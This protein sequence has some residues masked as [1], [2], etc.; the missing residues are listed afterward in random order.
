MRRTLTSTTICFAL[1]SACGSAH[2]EE[3]VVHE[4]AS[5]ECQGDTTAVWKL[6]GE[7][8]LG[9]VLK[10][11]SRLFCDTFFVE[12]ELMHEKIDLHFKP[13]NDHREL[14]DRLRGAFRAEGIDLDMNVSYDVR[15]GRS[16]ASLIGGESLPPPASYEKYIHCK[17]DQCELTR[18]GIDK[19]LANPMDLARQ[20]RI[21]PAMR[22]GK[23]SGIKLY[24][25][26]PGS[27]LALLGF[28]NGDLI[29]TVNDGDLSSP[30]KALEL[31]TALRTVKHIAVVGERA[32]ERFAINITIKD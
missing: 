5:K 3:L 12:R 10:E 30:A 9:V 15:R 8:Q 26:R 31:M 2:A 4:R 17:A 24:S 32:G 25:I 20:T 22:D 1:F 28:Q 14:R 16:S 6:Q 13:T 19:L 11:M 27:V 18:E 7:Q 29:L 23:L 21:V